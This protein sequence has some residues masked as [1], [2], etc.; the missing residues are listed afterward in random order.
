MTQ[1]N[2]NLTNIIQILSD[3]EKFLPSNSNTISNSVNLLEERLHSLNFEAN[4]FFEKLSIS[5][6]IS[7]E[8]LNTIMNL[9]SNIIIILNQKDNLYFEFKINILNFQIFLPIHLLFLLSTNA[10]T[11]QVEKQHSLEKLVNQIISFDEIPKFQKVLT[12]QEKHILDNHLRILGSSGDLYYLL[13][14]NLSL[15][16]EKNLITWSNR[17]F[18]QFYLLDLSLEKFDPL[19]FY[20]SNNLPVEDF[21]REIVGHYTILGNTN[22]T[23]LLEF[24]LGVDDT[25]IL[26]SI[27][28]QPYVELPSIESLENKLRNKSQKIRY[29]LGRVE[30]SKQNNKYFSLT[31]DP[32]NIISFKLMIALEKYFNFTISKIKTF[33]NEY[34]QL[35]TPASTELKNCLELCEDWLDSTLSLTENNENILDTPFGGL[36]NSVFLDYLL[37]LALDEGK[38]SSSSNNTFKTPNLEVKLEKYKHIFL[39]EHS[40]ESISDFIYVKT[41][42]QLY[43][44]SYLGTYYSLKDLVEEFYTLLHYLDKR[45][46]LKLNSLILIVTLEISISK[47]SFNSLSDL[48]KQI[49]DIVDDFKGLKHLRNDVEYYLEIIKT[50]NFHSFNKCFLKRSKAKILDINSWLIPN[51]SNLIKDSEYK[52]VKFISFNQLAD[53]IITSE[54]Q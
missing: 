29:L 4:E 21:Y 12:L 54:E 8:R 2:N 18:K 46:F 44:Y 9:L 41:Y 15:I 53:R 49:L 51:I 5:F 40:L 32:L 31:D 1:Q 52:E 37:L 19:D 30:E 16:K 34:N 45:P 25:K 35:T 7:D 50:K 11:I 26:E 13:C 39:T 24:I 22:A 14:S 42:A 33:E 20:Y 6:D 10:L 43:V 36:F 27:T 47:K 38:I 48:I 23:N 3:I 17:C 28:F